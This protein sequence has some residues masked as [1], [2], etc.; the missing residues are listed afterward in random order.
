VVGVRGPPWKSPAD[1]FALVGVAV[2][3]DD[4]LAARDAAPCAR[5]LD[6][7][8]RRAVVVRVHHVELELVDRA[9]VGERRPDPDRTVALA[10]APVDAQDLDVGSMV[11]A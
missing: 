1:W 11:W 8:R 7:A 9:M 10:D 4:V 2:D 6:H 3:V 5:V